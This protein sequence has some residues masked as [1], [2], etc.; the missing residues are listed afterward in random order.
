MT[1][2]N[3]GSVRCHHVPEEE[4]RDVFEKLQNLFKMYHHHKYTFEPACEERWAIFAAKTSAFN[5]LIVMAGKRKAM[6]FQSDKDPRN[7]EFA[8][9]D[10]ARLLLLNVDMASLLK[11]CQ[12]FDYKVLCEIGGIYVYHIDVQLSM[13]TA[14]LNDIL[15]YLSPYEPDMWTHFVSFSFNQAPFLGFGCTQICPT[16]IEELRRRLRGYQTVAK[17]L[18]G[19]VTLALEFST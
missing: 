4:Y 8:E 18:D 13:D 12:L 16:N 9:E 19:K 10:H 1:T 3:C 14:P 2:N 7:E 15:G 11:E 17:Y 6:L 5:V